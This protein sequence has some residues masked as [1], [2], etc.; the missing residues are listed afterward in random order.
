MAGK[1]KKTGNKAPWT[2]ERRAKFMATIAKQGKKVRGKKKSNR[3][4]PLAT[5]IRHPES[6]GSSSLTTLLNQLIEAA[7]EI[8]RRLG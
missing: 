1:K 8:K 5:Q 6:R 2:P 3:R 7:E 4:A